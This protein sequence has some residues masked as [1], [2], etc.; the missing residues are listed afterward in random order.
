MIEPIDIEGLPVMRSLSP[1][2]VFRDD[3]YVDS[4]KPVPSSSV[5]RTADE[6]QKDERA[7]KLLKNTKIPFD[8]IKKPKKKQKSPEVSNLENSGLVLSGCSFVRS[9]TLGAS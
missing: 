3:L 6:F 7:T 9:V 2:T 5:K 4:K 1:S 8:G